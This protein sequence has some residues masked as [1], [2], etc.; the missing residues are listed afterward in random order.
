MGDPTNTGPGSQEAGVEADIATVAAAIGD[1]SRTRVL[2]ALAGGAALPA[3][4]LAVEAGVSPATISGHLSKL[5]DAKLLTVERDGR[6]RFYRLASRDVARALE[7]LALLA[8]PVPARSLRRSTRARSLLRAR[9]CYDHLAGQ[10]GVD[11]MA[12][13]VRRGVLVADTEP[14]PATPSGHTPYESE[15]AAEYTVTSA[16]LRLLGE[17]GVELSSLTGRRNPSVRYCVDWAE[18]R[19]HL[20]GPLGAALTDRLFELGWLRRGRSHRMVA[21]T[22][23]GAAG[24]L[25]TFGVAAH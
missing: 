4:A 3:G 15:G 2:L 9:L 8:E 1:Q 25:D 20:A 12:A 14:L 22:D 19:P 16:G 23:A 24:L 21:L 18:R 13:L 10:L 11:L 5:L 6:H 17:L 7:S